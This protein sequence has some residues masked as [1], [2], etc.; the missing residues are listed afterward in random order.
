MISASPSVN[1]RSRLLL[2]APHPTSAGKRAQCAAV[3]AAHNAFVLL[4]LVML[5]LS[6]GVSLFVQT[7]FLQGFV[8]TGS[9]K[10]HSAAGA[11]EPAALKP[12]A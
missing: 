5:V 11:L 4:S 9:A 6:R 2:S 12:P 3:I 10:G 7:E 8:G 1:L